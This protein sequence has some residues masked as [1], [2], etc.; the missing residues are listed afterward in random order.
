MVLDL[1]RQLRAA[2]SRDRA[3]AVD[4]K[5]KHQLTLATVLNHSATGRKS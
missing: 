3:F 2:Q 5:A 1:I 4:F